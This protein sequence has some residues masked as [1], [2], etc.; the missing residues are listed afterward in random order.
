MLQILR[1]AERASLV[2]IFLTMAALF[3]FNVVARE[4]GG[5][6]A[7]Q[8]AWIEEAVRL[9]NTLLVF[10]GLGLALERG[11]HMGIDTLRDRLPEGLRIPLLKLIDAA[12]FA[13]SMYLVWLGYTLFEFVLRTGQRSPTL[14]VPM[15][16]VYLA[17]VIGFC[18]LGLRFALS[19]FGVIDRFGKPEAEDAEA[20]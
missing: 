15:G 19:F 9:L 13:F 10:L 20:Y 4:I 6:F 7:S 1:I 12:G 14:D 16:Y 3:F 11:R 2:V 17:P 8:F 18:L 5:S